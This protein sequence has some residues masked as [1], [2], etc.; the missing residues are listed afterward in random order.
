MADQEAPFEVRR[1]V[2]ELRCAP[3]RRDDAQA[4]VRVRVAGPRD[5]ELPRPSR[6]GPTRS[7]SVCRLTAASSVWRK[8]I[9]FE[10]G[11]H[12]KARQLRLNISS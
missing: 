3:G 5:R 4:D 8:A 11:L 9:R 12:Q 1:Q 10:S 6:S 7:T 2:D